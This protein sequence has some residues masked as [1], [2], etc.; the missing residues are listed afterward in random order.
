MRYILLRY[1]HRMPPKIKVAK[2]KFATPLLDKDAYPF[3]LDV[4]NETMVRRIT[5]DEKQLI[6]IHPMSKNP[7][8]PEGPEKIEIELEDY[9]CSIT[10]S[11]DKLPESGPLLKISLVQLVNDRSNKLFF[12]QRQSITSVYGNETDIPMVMRSDFRELNEPWIHGYVFAEGFNEETKKRKQQVIDNLLTLK[13]IIKN[14]KE[15]FSAMTT[16]PSLSTAKVAPLA[17]RLNG[18][19][20]DDHGKERTKNYITERWKSPF[21]LHPQSFFTLRRQEVASDNYYEQVLKTWLC[22]HC[23]KEETWISEIETTDNYHYLS[24]ITYVVTVFCSSAP[25]VTDFKWY[26]GEAKDI[27]CYLLDDLQG[28]CEDSAGRALYFIMDIYKKG[29]FWQRER[30]KN[31]LLNALYSG[32]KR[33]GFP[34]AIVGSAQE[35]GPEKDDKHT[36]NH[37][38]AALLPFNYFTKLFPV[39]SSSPWHE[40]FIKISKEPVI[41]LKKAA[42]VEGIV[43]TT[44]FY[45][46]KKH[47]SV[48]LEDI[49]ANM[50]FKL[51][52]CY[53][54]EQRPYFLDENVEICHDALRC[55]SPVLKDNVSRVFSYK[56]EAKIKGVKF[57]DLLKLKENIS[58]EITT[59]WEPKHVKAEQ[60]LLKWF[61]YPLF[62]D[63]ITLNEGVITRHFPLLETLEI[64]EV[65]LSFSTE[66]E[67][68]TYVYIQ[69]WKPIPNE[70]ILEI[71]EKIR[72]LHPE[73]SDCVVVRNLWSI[74]YFW[75]IKLTTV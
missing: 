9:S 13:E 16:L 46:A 33:L 60:N 26:N 51:K 63:Y 57:T 66:K 21:G 67:G 75:W 24:A 2:L 49:Y 43:L 1:T 32:L 64:T 29:P 62:V 41:P 22:Q 3:Y 28:D 12:Y 59:P 36:A 53:T 39:S 69:A 14:D 25:Y 68:Y 17:V 47:G 30:Y 4:Y 52:P 38:Y 15:V 8:Y 35:P 11:F 48:D 40:E 18:A 6:E 55:F 34:I 42:Y 70:I 56:E 54:N 7:K 61:A 58:T 19:D 37:M 23:V 73:T 65:T 44:P 20:F 31:P 45:H 5:I 27:D 50:P 71:T 74:R 72:K 10:I